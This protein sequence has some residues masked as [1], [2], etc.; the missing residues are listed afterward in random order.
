MF[1]LSRLS[2]TA[3]GQTDARAVGLIQNMDGLHANAFRSML[4]EV[5]LSGAVP[6]TR[7][8]NST[9]PLNSTRSPTFKAQLAVY[10]NKVRAPTCYNPLSRRIFTYPLKVFSVSCSFALAACGSISVQPQIE[11]FAKAT[12]S[13]TM[14]INVIADAP[15]V[16]AEADAARGR[17]WANAGWKINVKG[18]HEPVH[19]FED[20][21]AEQ[22]K[23]KGDGPPDFDDACKLEPH[24]ASN[25]APSVD[26]EADDNPAVRTLN[27]QTVATALGNYAEALGALAASDTPEK[28]GAALSSAVTAAHKL[29]GVSIEASGGEISAERVKLLSS[30]GTLLTELGREA[31]Q[32]YRLAQLRAAVT[33]ASPA[34]EKAA[35]FL[36]AWQHD[37]ESAELRSSYEVLAETVAAY[38]TSMTATDSRRSD[39]ALLAAEVFSQSR[40]LRAAENGT[41]W[42]AFASI[43][44]AHA[45]LLSALE[46]PGD[47]DQLVAANSRVIELIGTV[48]GFVK[49]VEEN[50]ARTK[51][52]Q[53]GI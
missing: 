23:R 24:N 30:G 8:S 13:A 27:A 16:E 46:N 33:F 17:S 15:N 12:R 42:R 21:S 1:Y 10:V 45:S 34:V 41:K 14:A 18:C 7:P 4:P 25:E 2:P 49:A 28:A 44:S 20:R 43:K 50:Q 35:T 36:A 9:R 31:F 6:A 47:V 51:S 22:V 5:A 29:G 19:W 39:A 53:G 40:A 3:D 26:R 32:I 37:L 48:D 52:K 11:A 38:N